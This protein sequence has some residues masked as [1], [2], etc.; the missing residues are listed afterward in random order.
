[1][2]GI[3]CW[4]FSLCIVA[5]YAQNNRN[6]DDTISIGGNI[7]DEKGKP[8]PFVSVNLYRH[9]AGLNVNNSG[10][11]LFFK[12]KQNDSLLFTCTGY[13]PAGTRL[14]VPKILQ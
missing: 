9:K 13:Y 12:L 10:E 1:M 5:V 8:I 6:G 14:K 2:K 4:L 11:F 7:V 3:L